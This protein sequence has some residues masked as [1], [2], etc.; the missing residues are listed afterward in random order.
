MQAP[1][2]SAQPTSKMSGFSTPRA[3]SA[4]KAPADPELSAE[5]ARAIAEEAVTGTGDE[6]LRAQQE[7]AQ[8]TPVDPALAYEQRI[9]EFGLDINQA[10]VI[11]DALTVDGFYQEEFAL[12]KTTKAVFCSRSTRFNSFLADR[13][14]IADPKKVGKLNQMMAEYQVAASLASYGPHVMPEIKDSM[15]V[16]EWEEALNR[17]LEF[18]RLLASPVFL[19]LTNKLAKFD[20]KLMT[21]L[22][23]GYEKNF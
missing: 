8:E 3:P 10:L 23:E 19:L 14:D 16:K 11:I 22:S 15:P 13:I 5:A 9:K 12:S 4:A 20:A 2:P 6:A 7:K 1:T 18:V 17:R 21:V